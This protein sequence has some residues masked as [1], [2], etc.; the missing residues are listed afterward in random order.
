MYTG[1]QMTSKTISL[2]EE[3]YDRL[4]RARGADESF[5]DV[6]DRLLEVDDDSHPLYGLVGLATESDLDRIRER[7]REFRADVEKRTPVEATPPVGPDR[8]ADGEGSGE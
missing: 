5:S 1:T 6:I 8:T 7:S 2:K 3:T 4:R